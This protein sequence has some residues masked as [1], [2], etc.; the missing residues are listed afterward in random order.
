MKGMNNMNKYLFII[1]GTLLIACSSSRVLAQNDH[2][3]QYMQMALVAYNN[4]HY[5]LAITY[6]E[7]ALDDNVDW[8]PAF[9][10]LGNCYYA[11]GKINEALKNYSQALKM[12]PDN[13]MSIYMGIGNCCLKMNRTADALKYYQAAL[14]IQPGNTALANYVKALQARLGIVPTPVPQVPNNLPLQNFTTPLASP[15]PIAVP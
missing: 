7:S 3:P 13:P 9:L 11:K 12:H 1:V 5:D 15:T 2:Y 6:Y 4:N 10:G 14:N 8:W